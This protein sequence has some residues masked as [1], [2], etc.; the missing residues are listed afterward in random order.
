M[1]KRTVQVISSVDAICIHFSLTN[2]C[3]AP[4]SSVHFTM[5]TAFQHE[6]VSAVFILVL[7]LLKALLNQ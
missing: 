5:H 7:T 2:C 3:A 4:S 6:L 1:A